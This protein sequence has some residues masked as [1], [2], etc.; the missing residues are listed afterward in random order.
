MAVVVTFFVEG[1]L[2]TLKLASGFVD[3]RA[4]CSRFDVDDDGEF[5]CFGE[6]DEVGFHD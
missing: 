2:H 5:P 6:G 1:F 4:E 3:R